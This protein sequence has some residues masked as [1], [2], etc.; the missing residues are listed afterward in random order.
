[1]PIDALSTAEEVAYILDDC[2]PGVVLA[3]RGTAPVLERALTLGRAR[4][5]VLVLDDVAIEPS[6]EGSHKSV[7]VDA[8][9][10][11]AI[12]YTS[13]TT[14]KSQG[15]D[16]VGGQPRRQ[17]QRRDCVPATTDPRRGC[18]CSCPS[19]TSCPWPALSWPLLS[20]VGTV[21]FATSLAGEALL[22]TLQ[23]NAVTLIVGVPRFYD[24][25]HRALLR[26][27]PGEPRRSV[28]LRPGTR[29][30][31][32]ARSH[33]SCLGP[34]TDASAVIFATSSAVA[35]P[36]RP[37]RPAPSTSSASTSAKGTG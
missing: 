19:T 17:R 31:D 30:S 14:G 27:D 25:L 33:V 21:V 28:T 10:T 7:A 24:M 32:R 11:L 5:R 35:P 1:M 13:G 34:F 37:R 18:C 22:A 2:T 29:A 26:E 3:S 6:A 15:R 20:R 16:A 9:H 8:A 12:I 4:P 36:C 23:R